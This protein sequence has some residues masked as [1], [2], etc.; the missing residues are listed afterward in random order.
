MNVGEG[1]ILEIK[2]K[3]KKRWFFI[4]YFGVMLWGGM[5]GLIGQ[6]TGG[7]LK[8]KIIFNL[9]CDKFSLLLVAVKI[10]NHHNNQIAK[11]RR[12]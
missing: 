12:L 9:S 2:K 1:G 4:F 10:T 5:F 3:K 7:N 6:L 8:N 11:T